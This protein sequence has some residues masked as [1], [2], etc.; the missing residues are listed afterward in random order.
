MW[1]VSIIQYPYVSMVS[2]QNT[3]WFTQE[4]DHGMGATISGELWG[5]SNKLVGGGGCPSQVKA[6]IPR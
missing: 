5:I 3:A 1:E 4:N 2:E 6:I